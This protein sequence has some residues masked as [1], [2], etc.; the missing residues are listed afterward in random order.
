[1][2][3]VTYSSDQR[4]NQK[5][6][7]PVV[8]ST[9]NTDTIVI[10]QQTPTQTTKKA[11]NPVNPDMYKTSPVIIQCPDCGAIVTTNVM[12][13]CN[14]LACF[15]CCITACVIYSCVQCCKGKDICCYDAIHSCPACGKQVGSYVAC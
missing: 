4:S 2:D 13:S 7:K 10:I 9:G 3:V 8:Q 15:C 1:M 11:V 12:K 14:C 5:Y 6:G